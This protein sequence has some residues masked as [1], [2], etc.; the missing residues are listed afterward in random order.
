[1]KL[2]TYQ[3]EGVTFA[4]KRRAT[5]LADEMGLGKTAQAIG[6]IN[7]EQT[8]K[9]LVLVICPA[10]LKWNWIEEIKMWCKKDFHV[11]SFSAQKG[12]SYPND[13][14]FDVVSYDSARL[15]PLKDV[16]FDVVIADEAHYLKSDKSQRYQRFEPIARKAKRLLLLTGTPIPNRIRELFP[17]LSLLDAKN[18]NPEKL[19]PSSPAG[20]VKPHPFAAL[21]AKGLVAPPQNAKP[22]KPNKAYSRD[23]FN[24]A[25]RY[26]GAELVEIPGRGQFMDGEWQKKTAWKFDGASN[27][28]ELNQR[29][30]QT[31]MVR[32]TKEQVLKE[33]P[34]K[35]RQ[36]IILPR[37]PPEC[38][39]TDW[40]LKSELDESNY[41]E[42]VKRL[43][44]DKV[45]FKDWSETRHRQGKAK[46][47]YV[48]EHIQDCYESGSKK[49]IVFGHHTDVLTD[50]YSVLNFD[51][52]VLVT[53]KTSQKERQDAIDIFQ[54]DPNCHFFVGSL[55]ACGTGINLT[56]ASHVI[57]SE[58][59]PA[60]YRLLQGEDRAHR[61]GQRQMVLVQ[62][63]VWNGT[64]DSRM[65]KI[66]M[67][68]LEVQYAA[69]K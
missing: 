18:W 15:E 43:E 45:K 8:T 68:K 46:V 5:L 64:L 13:V 44:A 35:R 66:V 61:M 31:I 67:G 30:R 39:D 69:L 1:M 50:I 22:I 63:V 42:F 53:G 16:V 37:I 60:P 14:E 59:D 11:V 47:P 57:F 2:T 25:K 48:I 36:L 55:G 41:D 17:L 7:A 26:C 32:R 58:F 65:A 20:M 9:L 33:L 38:E 52:A 24:F 21:M 3:Q 10:Y 23:F 51:G 40:M 4:M 34:P 12:N 29:L 28:E 19:Q 54:D 6:V 62:H 56:A 49:I 27:L